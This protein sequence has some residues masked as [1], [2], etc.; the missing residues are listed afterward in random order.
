MQIAYVPARD[1][2]EPRV[3]ERHLLLAVLARRVRRDVAHR[4][5]PVESDE[6]DQV[7]ELGRLDQPERLAHPGRLELEDPG[8]LAGREHRVRRAVVERERADVEPARQLH[9]LVDHVQVAQ[10]EEVHLQQAELDDVVHPELGHDF[11]V[12]ALLLERDDV[13]Q[14][15]RA[16]H[17]AGR[18]DRV[19]SRETLERLGEVEDLLRDRVRVHRL[20]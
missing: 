1:L 9:G 18:V 6:R 2:L 7:L 5:W 19:R 13:D 12:G 10:A 3:R 14:R 4:P 16:D 8:R 20:P 11:L 17:D 15:P